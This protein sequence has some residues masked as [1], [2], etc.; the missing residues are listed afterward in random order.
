MS[1]AADRFRLDPEPS[2]Q[3]DLQ[4]VARFLQLLA[5]GPKQRHFVCSPNSSARVILPGNKI[6]RLRRIRSSLLS[7][8]VP[9]ARAGFNLCAT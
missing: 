8:S 4:V 3:P 1:S 6:S 2:Y 7:P 9:L 5:T